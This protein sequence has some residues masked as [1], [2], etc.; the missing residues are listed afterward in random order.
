MGICSSGSCSPNW[1]TKYKMF[2]TTEFPSSYIH[3]SFISTRCRF[4][5][6][7]LHKFC[8][9][10][11][12]YILNSEKIKKR[13]VTG[14]RWK[15]YGALNM[16]ASSQNYSNAF[17]WKVAHTHTCLHTVDT[18]SRNVETWEWPCKTIETDV[19]ITV[20]DSHDQQSWWFI[21]FYYTKN[22]HSTT[23]QK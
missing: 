5:P 22:L 15:H 8:C 4:L 1:C 2:L 13:E 3:V 14:I 17:V 9:G 7:Q 20:H 18:P 21:F 12:T 6:F 23:K 19:C 10:M 16:F 11:T